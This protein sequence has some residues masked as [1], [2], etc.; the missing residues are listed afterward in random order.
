MPLK[1][2]VEKQ[3]KGDVSGFSIAFLSNVNATYMSM[4]TLSTQYLIVLQ[5]K[6]QLNIRWMNFVIVKMKQCSKYFGR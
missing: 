4:V 3:L 6:L 1:I 2:Y 5:E